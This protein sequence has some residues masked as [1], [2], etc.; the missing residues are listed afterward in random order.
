MAKKQLRSNKRHLFISLVIFTRPTE[1]PKKAIESIGKLSYPSHSFEL[2]VIKGNNLS[3]QR[4][5]AL[6]QANGTIVYFLD[7]DSE[8]Q[9]NALLL[10]EQAFVNK[11]V[12]AVGGPSI[13]PSNE[14]RYISSVT[15][16][17]LQTHFGAL[18]M[19]LRYSKQGNK[20]LATQFH[21]IG[22]NLALR[23]LAVQKIGGFDE[24][25]I[26]NEETELLVRLQKKGYKLLYIP[27]LFIFRSQRTSI[28]LLWK[29]FFSYGKGRTKQLKKS[30]TIN[31][32]IF[33]IPVLFVLYLLSLL[34]VHT[35][36]WILPLLCYLA[37]S[38]AT[39][40][41]AA[42]KYRRA[43]LFFVMP[44][45]FPII[46]IAYACGLIAEMKQL[47]PSPKQMTR[48]ARVS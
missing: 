23:K 15:G 38:F 2:I 27:E 22:A 45:F 33:M 4:N 7:N 26:P 48:M 18:R 11:Q 24:T 9:P 13:S 46:H 41:K 47:I 37:L 43:D 8:V 10:I 30:R 28:G 25:I 35:I 16:Y 5:I 29:Q 1:S 20:R 39:S 32:T 17:I 44:L 19:R 31:D 12:G 34:F 42:I 3:K 14:E 6:S 36:L 40:L 21:L